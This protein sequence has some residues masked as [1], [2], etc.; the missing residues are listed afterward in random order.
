MFRKMI[1]SATLIA[2]M[3]TQSSATIY[4]ATTSGNYAAP[5]TWGGSAPSATITADTIIVPNGITV[6]FN[7]DVVL[8]NNAGLTV[9]GTLQSTSNYLTTAGAMVSG[10]GSI[11]ADSIL[12]NMTAGGFI[13][14]GSVTANKLAVAALSAN[15]GATFIVNNKCHL[16]AGTFDIDG[17]TLNMAANTE[18]IVRSGKLGTTGSP[19]YNFTNPYIVRYVA[20]ASSA[21]NPG[22]ELTG[23]GLKEIEVAASAG[24]PFILNKHL[25]INCK[26]VLTSGVFDLS[27]YDLEF[28][29]DG[30]LD[31]SG[32]G[33]FA[34]TSQSNMTINA[35]AG[36][37][38]PI[39]FLSAGSAT[40][41]NFTMNLGNNTKS[42]TLGNSMKVTG[43]LNLQSGRL[44]LGNNNLSLIAGG[45]IS[46]G[47]SN[48]YV[49]TDG[50]GTLVQDL[51]SNSTKVWHIGTAGHYLPAMAG[52]SNLSVFTGMNMRVQDGVLSHGTTGFSL[53]GRS[54]VNATWFV[55]SASASTVD[56]NLELMW[57][58]G[59][60]VNGFNHNIAFI[61]QN[62][63][64]GWD[65]TNVQP[66]N[67]GSNGL[68]NIKREGITTLSAYTVA[69]KNAKL[70]VEN[71]AAAK[72]IINIY[73]NPANNVLHVAMQ[74]TQPVQVYIFN[75]AGQVVY[76][77]PLQNN[78]ID[79]S[80][81][82][83]GM[84]YLKLQG[85][86]VNATTKFIKQ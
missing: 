75:T 48:S 20:P 31:A 11:S 72:K 63:G 9:D 69:D 73:P 84:Y 85:N 37:S 30:D 71:V 22:P 35:N 1:L 42:V 24:N 64:S 76:N 26:L 27:I 8:N 54:L 23:S 86:H 41:K 44:H 49:V 15:N 59:A 28:G 25:T 18:F 34:S 32:T 19:V 81:L 38:G 7:Q 5:A 60:E 70:S 77:A 83:H 57:D 50:S 39:R 10:S 65:T 79:V 68:F 55:G 46:G 29:P 43:S 21:F 17:S 61:A 67:T 14:S 3:C 52:S 13:F 12:L 56:M 6:T 45:T 16:L 47:S 62:N 82:Q 53:S 36:L 51:G 33:A 2:G 66:V 40:V 58:A 4:T 80:A 74:S 78:A